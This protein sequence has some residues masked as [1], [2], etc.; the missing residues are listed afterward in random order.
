MTGDVPR[1]GD[2]VRE[3]ADA[4]GADAAGARVFPEA[5]PIPAWLEQEST[6]PRPALVMTAPQILPFDGLTSEDFERLVLRY[7][8]R[9]PTVEH[10]GLYGTRGQNQQGVDL[11]A[12]LW[13]PGPGGRRYMT[14]QCHNVS[15][16][17]PSAIVAATDDF[18]AGHWAQQAAVFVLATR[19]STRSTQQ[20]EAIEAAARKVEA[21]GCRLEVWDG[22]A[23]SERLRD[24][25]E[26]VEA[27]FA[28]G[29]A[30][31]FCAVA[32]APG[33]QC[34]RADSR[35]RCTTMASR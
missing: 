27:F 8:R 30:L 24:L 6:G 20:I 35:G 12:R 10:C 21:A 25:P 16:M 32:H 1:H 14:V 28:H 13:V 29:T 18:L 3:S 33:P 5:E 23:L 19:A 34:H 22:E 17:G 31:A 11:Y 15:A 7:V 4:E 26:L 2:E 9:D